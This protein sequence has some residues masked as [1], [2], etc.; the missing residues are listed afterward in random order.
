MLLLRRWAVVAVLLTG[1]LVVLVVLRSFPALDL[2]WFNANAHLVAV[3]LIAALAL[4]AALAALVTAGRS[5]QPN[6]IWLGVGCVAVGLGML[7]HGLTT[8]GV[9]GRPNNVWVGRFPYLAM[10]VFAVCLSAAGRPPTWRPNRFMRRHIGVSIL[11]PIVTIGALVTI[12]S[13]HP[14]TLSGTSSYSWEENVYDVATVVSIVLLLL[15]MRTHWQRWQLG[16]DIF[17]FA[18]VLAASASIAA[19]VAFEHGSFSHVSWWDY[20]GYLMAGFGGAVYAVFRRRNDERTLSDVLNSAFVDDPF[21]HI[22]SGYP[23]ALRSLVRAVEVKD[24]YTHG[25]S[26]RTARMAVELGL[27]MGLASDQLRVIARGAYLHDVG[28]IGIP[29]GILNKPGALTPDEWKVIQTHPQLGYELASA[30]PS[31]REALPVILHHHERIDGQGYPGHLA[32]NQ[33]PLE[34]RVVAVADV[35]DALTSDR[36]YRKG[37]E[38]QM[39]LAHIHD[40]AGTHF[41][42]HVV[43]ALIRL[44]AEWGIDDHAR[45]GM[46]EVAW[47]AAE[48]CH[49]IDDDQL[50]SV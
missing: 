28:K 14:T 34:A 45:T 9:F 35:W 30:A 50:V 23:E 17:Q 5:G 29:D 12:I 13:I 32:G 21:E 15:A 47:Q 41:D 19:F 3:S 8:P 24:T 1:P 39:A 16:H 4:A 18:V 38:P 27:S 6:V 42:P 25:H 20:H 33:I 7:G 44:V 48:T 10:C 31:L 37:W 43:D 2:Q 11:I 26:E 22:V 46:A 40:G 36:A 49:K